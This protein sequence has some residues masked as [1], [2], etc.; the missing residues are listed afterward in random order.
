MIIATII[1]IITHDEDGRPNGNDNNNID[2][3]DD[4]DDVYD[5]DDDDD[6]DDNDNNFNN[7]ISSNN[8]SIMLHC[9][10]ISH[11][12][13][14]HKQDTSKQETDIQMHAPLRVKINYLY[15]ILT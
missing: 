8:S 12:I 14:N 5:D 11:I 9:I 7:T 1:A 13:Q 6:D 3:D 2:D 4:D 10:F 15:V